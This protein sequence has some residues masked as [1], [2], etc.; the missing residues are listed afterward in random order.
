MALSSACAAPIGPNN[1]PAHRPAPPAA[2][3]LLPAVPLLTLDGQRTSLPQLVGRRVALVSLWATW[4][5]PCLREFPAL[6]RFAAQAPPGAVLGVAVAV[7]EPRAQVADFV[8]ARG[9]GYQHLV[10]EDFRFADA[11]GQKRVPATLVA[12]REGHVTFSG[13]A[14]DEAAL[15][16]VQSLLGEGALAST[17]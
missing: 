5:D 2:P 16:A 4:C 15:A 7:G 13:G 11:L 14:L 9:L 17:R 10:D 6:Q 8:S 1:R 12:D 3:G